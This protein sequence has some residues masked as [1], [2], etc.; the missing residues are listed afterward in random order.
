MAPQLY[1]LSWILDARS[2][3]NSIG[4]NENAFDL[5]NRKW[6]VACKHV[7]ISPAHQIPRHKESEKV[8]VLNP[9]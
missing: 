4:V 6:L 7:L 1:D 2:F 9:F 8:T 5:N 3:V